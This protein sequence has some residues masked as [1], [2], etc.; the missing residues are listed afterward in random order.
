MNKINFKNK[1]IFEFNNK[2]KNKGFVALTLIVFVS[3]ILLAFSFTNFIEFGHF[4]DETRV[5]KNRL[6][7]S[8]YAESCMNIA[9]LTLAKDYFFTLQNPIDIV[10]LKCSID[11]VI[12][13]GE[14][15][16]IT[17]HGNW[18]NIKVFLTKKVLL[19]DTSI[20]II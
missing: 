19:Q 10:E 12:K 11:S 20:E 5:K 16:I 18:Q 15:R 14:M 7:S 2:N 9:L 8:Y 3:A 6:M 1:C 17:T 4:F 13:N